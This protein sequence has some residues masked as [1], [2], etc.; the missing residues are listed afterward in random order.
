V[1]NEVRDLSQHSGVNIGHSELVVDHMMRT[2][3]NVEHAIVSIQT[4]F[5]GKSEAEV[6]LAG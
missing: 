1:L 3:T 4:V 6:L 5:R 2:K